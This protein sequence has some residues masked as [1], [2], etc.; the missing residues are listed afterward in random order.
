MPGGECSGKTVKTKQNSSE[1][2][3]VHTVMNIL[4]GYWPFPSYKN[5]TRLL[6]C[7]SSNPNDHVCNPLGNVTSK[8]VSLSKTNNDS[9]NDLD[10]KYYLLTRLKA[11]A[12]T[13]EL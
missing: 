12:I 2:N 11:R 3:N 8:Y 5:T 13:K 10:T 6:K 1:H 9:R 4:V 7:S